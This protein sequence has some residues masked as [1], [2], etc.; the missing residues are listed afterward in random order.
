[1]M[2]VSSTNSD[3]AGVQFN[4]VYGTSYIASKNILAET[5]TGFH[6]CFTSNDKFNKDDPHLKIKK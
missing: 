6:R 1:M 2:S 3:Y 4:S 5:F